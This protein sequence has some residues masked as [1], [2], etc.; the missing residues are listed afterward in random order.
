MYTYLFSKL[1]QNIIDIL[2]KSK[3]YNVMISYIYIFII[4][5]AKEQRYEH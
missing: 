3:V 2:Y 4:T 5:T 1:Y